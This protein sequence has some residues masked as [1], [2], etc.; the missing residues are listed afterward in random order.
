MIDPEYISVTAAVIEKDGKVL[1]ARRKRPFM[2]YSWEFPGGKLE[3]NE[4]LE[5]CLKREIREELAIEIEVGPLVSLNKHVLNCQSAIILYAYRARFL[6][7]NIELIDHNEIK[8]VLPED[9]IK[10]DFPDPDRLIAKKIFSL[11]TNKS[12]SHNMDLKGGDIM[13]C[14]AKGCGTTK[15]ATTKKA[16]PKKATAKKTTKK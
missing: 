15:K 16:T 7:G 9:L 8:W 4:T 10:Y 6:S 13:T 12:D 11:L 1:I 3:D 5:E 14:G 2:G